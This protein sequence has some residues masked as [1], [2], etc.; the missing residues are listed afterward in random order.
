MKICLRIFFLGDF[1]G[2][3][4]RVVKRKTA[5]VLFFMYI[6]VFFSILFPNWLEVFFVRKIGERDVFVNVAILNFIKFAKVY[7]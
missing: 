4:I 3:I 5:H 1:N 6:R 7:N 2:P